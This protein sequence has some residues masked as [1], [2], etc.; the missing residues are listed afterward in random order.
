MGKSTKHKAVLLALVVPHL[1][2][3]WGLKCHFPC[4]SYLCEFA[5]NPPFH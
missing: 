4:Q 1:T 3:G 2:Y 5:S